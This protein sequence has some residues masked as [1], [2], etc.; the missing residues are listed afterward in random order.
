MLYLWV[1]LQP[2]SLRAD[3]SLVHLRRNY[4]K[5]IDG[6]V[7]ASRSKFLRLLWSLLLLLG[8]LRSK[9]AARSDGARTGGLGVLRRCLLCAR[10]RGGLGLGRGRRLLLSQEAGSFS[11][12]GE[13]GAPLLLLLLL[14]R[15]AG[16]PTVL[17][18][19]CL[20]SFLYNQEAQSSEFC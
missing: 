8:R 4:L 1:S 12:A 16:L 9:A 2:S 18:L 11:F 13:L 7:N 5:K 14:G 15:F 17:P 10:L 3:T 20:L 6:I 19:R